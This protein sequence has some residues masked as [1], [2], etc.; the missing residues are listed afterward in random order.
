MDHNGG[1]GSK[2]SKKKILPN[3]NGPNNF[4][5]DLETIPIFH[6]HCHTHSGNTSW[7]VNLAVLRFL[8]SYEDE[9]EYGNDN[10]NE[11]ED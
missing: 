1:V 10:G 6:P 4:T 5:E 3:N 9:N 8:V 7:P 2:K 11:I